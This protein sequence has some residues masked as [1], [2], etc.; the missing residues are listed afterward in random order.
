M[1]ETDERGI[2]LHEVI[3]GHEKLD[4]SSMSNANGVKVEKLSLFCVSLDNSTPRDS[5]HSRRVI[6]IR[7][8]L[9]LVFLGR[10]DTCS[11]LIG[12]AEKW[13]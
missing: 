2:E 7:E 9:E 10:R 6:Y 1:N 3:V 4:G 12:N 5:D 13:L 8:T 11:S